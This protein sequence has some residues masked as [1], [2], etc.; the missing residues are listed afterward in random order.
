LSLLQNHLGD[1][2]FVIDFNLTE[3]NKKNIVPQIF[4]NLYEEK[5]QNK[6]QI[7]F[8]DASK[9]KTSIAFGIINSSVHKF[10]IP[11]LNSK[12]IYCRRLS[13]PKINSSNQ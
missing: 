7:L 13:D 5:T 6:D 1:Q 2:S 12:I 10:R 11:A 4:K 3:N 8:T 9:T